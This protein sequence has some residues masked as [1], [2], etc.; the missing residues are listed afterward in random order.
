MLN[1][2]SRPPL[3]NKF[4]LNGL[5]S[6]PLTAPAC[7]FCSVV[8]THVALACGKSSA[9]STPMLLVNDDDD[10]KPSSCPSW[11]VLF[12]RELFIFRA[13]VVVRLISAFGSY[14]CTVPSANPP[15]KI[16][17]GVRSETWSFQHRRWNRSATAH[18]VPTTSQYPSL[19]FFVL[20]NSSSSKDA[21]R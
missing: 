18:P 13:A 8:S 7:A 19:L 4:E 20:L 11:L 15:A 6:R 1:S 5:K 10:A 9:S 14:N 21:S 17:L 12:F 3:A 16:P 2:P